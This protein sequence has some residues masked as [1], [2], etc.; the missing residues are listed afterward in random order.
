MCRQQFMARALGN[1]IAAKQ[2]EARRRSPTR[3][4]PPAQQVGGPPG[5]GAPAPVPQG[6]QV[7]FGDSWINTGI[8]ANPLTAQQR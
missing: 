7:A 1:K 4:G 5:Y 8:L 2:N 3:A 6:V